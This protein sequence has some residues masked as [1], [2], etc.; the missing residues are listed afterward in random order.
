MTKEIC[1]TLGSRVK[2]CYKMSI[3]GKDFDIKWRTLIHIRDV[4]KFSLLARLNY[5]VEIALAMGKFFIFTNFTGN[6]R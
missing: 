4:I 2:L 3:I 6:Y 5:F 1:N